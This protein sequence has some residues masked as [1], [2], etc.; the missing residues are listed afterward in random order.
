MNLFSIL[1][2]S[3]LLGMANAVAITRDTS[4][5]T[6]K[7]FRVLNRCHN[8][9]TGHNDCPESCPCDMHNIC[10]PKCTSKSLTPTM[11]TDHW[12]TNINNQNKNRYAQLKPAPS[13]LFGKAQM[14]ALESGLRFI[15]ILLL[16]ILDWIHRDITDDPDNAVWLATV[17]SIWLW[18]EPASM[19]LVAWTGEEDAIGVIVLYPWSARQVNAI[20]GQSG[21]IVTGSSAHPPNSTP[22]SKGKHGLRA[23]AAGHKAP[24][25]L[26][27][28]AKAEFNSFVVSRDVF[29]FGHGD[30]YWGAWTRKLPLEKCDARLIE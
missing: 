7:E 16:K 3:A 11:Q 29:Y 24:M 18:L 22:P 15:L 8:I 14:T 6:P 1:T 9:C 30:K 23:R 12:N 2:F 25:A 5:A 26:E 27:T 13:Y 17:A 20:A 21:H 28:L 10:A 19:V 4:S